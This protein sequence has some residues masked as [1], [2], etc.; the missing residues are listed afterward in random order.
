MVEKL[1]IQLNNNVSELERFYDSLLKIASW[2][3]VS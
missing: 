2:T 1:A 3:I